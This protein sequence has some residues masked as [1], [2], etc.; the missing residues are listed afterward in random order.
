[1]KMCADAK[2]FRRWSKAASILAEVICAPFRREGFWQVLAVGDKLDANDFAARDA[3][4]ERL[5]LEVEAAGY[6]R[7]VYEWVWDEQNCAQLVLDV[8][9]GKKEASRRAEAY[10][11]SGIHTRLK[12]IE[13]ETFEGL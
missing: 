2:E 11:R 6:C 9:K 10:E 12:K 13:A 1:M 4:R 3:V 5:R 8:V 7:I